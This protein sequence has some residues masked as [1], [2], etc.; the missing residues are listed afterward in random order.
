MVREAT[1]EWRRTSDVGLRFA[2]GHLKADPK[3]YITAATLRAEFNAY[4]GSQGKHPWTATTLNE[5]F[6]ASLA[7]AGI[8]IWASP[9]K[10][11]RITAA[12]TESH[13]EP[14][15]PPDG[16]YLEEVKKE[17]KKVTPLHGR[18][19]GGAPPP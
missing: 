11:A 4:L 3:C 2:A 13:P 15:P 16:I 5:R 17:A 14:P 1:D 7:A 19:D 10:L 12:H 6:P 9:R 8:P 18:R